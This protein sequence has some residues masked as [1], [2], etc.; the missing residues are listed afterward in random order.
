MLRLR[1]AFA[2]GYDRAGSLSNGIRNAKNCQVAVARKMGNQ[3]A[4]L[5]WLIEAI[6]TAA[7]SGH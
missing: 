7:Q 4:I 5:V 2:K 3:D 6:L 1:S